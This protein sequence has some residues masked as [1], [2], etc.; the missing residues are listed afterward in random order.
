MKYKRFLAALLTALL[1][2]SCLGGCSAGNRELDE[3][4]KKSLCETDWTSGSV[5]WSTKKDSGLV[6]WLYTFHADGTGTRQDQYKLK[7]ESA[8]NDQ[9][10]YD[11]T[12][13]FIHSKGAVYLRI[14]TG[15][16]QD[17]YLVTYD[18][19]TGSIRDFTG[20]IQF[21]G[22]Y[23]ATYRRNQATAQ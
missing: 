23:T 4:L 5:S 18:A 7:G 15:A 10:P 21:R 19:E 8:W 9:G 13:K 17:D 2:L 11:L 12:Y 20:L 14:D 1:I 6:R 16:S 22:D 3:A